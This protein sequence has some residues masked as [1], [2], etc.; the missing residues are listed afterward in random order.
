MLKDKAL[1]LI[2]V[3]DVAREILDPRCKAE[4]MDGQFSDDVTG[5]DFKIIYNYKYASHSVEAHHKAIKSI[6]Q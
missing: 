3:T 6:L 4:T 5:R 2:T 1:T